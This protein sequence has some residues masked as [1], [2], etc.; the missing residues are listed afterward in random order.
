M[1]TLY[2]L[3]A[4][5]MSGFLRGHLSALRARGFEP[6]VCVPE[7]TNMAVEL[8]ANEGVELVICPMR[9]DISLL[10]DFVSYIRLTRLIQHRRPDLTVTIGPKAALLG[11]LAAATCQVPC[12]I[13]TKWGIRLETTR[14]LLRIVL[15]IADKIASACAQMV[16]CDS[17][18]GRARTI[19]LGLAP[20]EKVRV[21]ASGSANGIDVS[22]FELTAANLAAA[23]GFRKKI[24]A[25]AETPVVG[26]VGRISKDK[27]LAEMLGAWPLIRSRHP[28]AILALIGSTEC[29]SEAE[30]RQ[31]AQLITL[32]GV[33]A[34]GPQYGLEGVFPAFDIL[35]LPSH[36]EG[37]GVVVLE[38]G[39]VGVPTVGFSVTGMIDSVVPGETGQ[40]VPL[41]DLEGLVAATNLY[42]SDRSLRNQHGEAARHRV[43]KFFRQEQ[44]WQGYF[45]AFRLAAE[46]QALD[47]S[48]LR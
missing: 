47:V 8:A 17:E 41:G 29:H 46:E 31:L 28:S 33:K 3:T 18:S 35:L 26:F 13:Q 40:L 25:A 12:R 15:I 37:F 6:T 23:A 10:A 44:V 1:R 32:P 24:G 38:A 16:L 21:V 2:I 30:Q 22:R 19:E 45:E 48:E 4:P 20:A 9:R 11:G 36:R 43:L 7:R 34:L 42:L 39:A 14:G 27:G 5:Q